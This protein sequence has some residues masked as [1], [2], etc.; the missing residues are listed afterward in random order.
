VLASR[1]PFYQLT[2]GAQIAF[3]AA[4]IAGVWTGAPALRIPAFL[5]SSNAAILIAW[6]RF[7]SGERI[8]CWNPSERLTSLPQTES[9]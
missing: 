5:L 7:A 3:Y 9:H 4:A 2:F 1:S 8:T 6:L